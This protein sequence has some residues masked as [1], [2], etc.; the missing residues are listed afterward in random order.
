MKVDKV[1]SK[2]TSKMLFDLFEEEF[3]DEWK[4]FFGD[5]IG[6]EEET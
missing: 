5:K 4:N 2:E 1:D 3:E 6:K